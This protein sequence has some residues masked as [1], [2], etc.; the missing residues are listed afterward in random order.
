MLTVRI[1][2]FNYSYLKLKLIF[3]NKREQIVF[4]VNL[5]RRQFTLS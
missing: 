4:Y 5:Q 1:A 2:N 3:S